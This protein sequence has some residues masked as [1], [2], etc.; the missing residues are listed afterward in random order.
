LAG[1]FA[2][3]HAADLVLLVMALEVSLLVALRGAEAK[4]LIVATLP[5]ALIVLALRAALVGADWRW[6]A[7]PLALSWPIHLLDLRMRRRQAG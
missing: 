2:S 4:P 6:I 7:L 1:L 5:G 3:G